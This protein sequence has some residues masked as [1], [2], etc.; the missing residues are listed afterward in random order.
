[1]IFKLIK[2]LFISIFYFFITTK[3]VFSEI[4]KDFNFIGNDRISD[5]TIKMFSEISIDEDLDASTLN[6]ILKNLYNTNF[7][8]NI[9]VKLENNI[10]EI[11]V[12]ENPIIEK[13]NYDGIK[14]KRINELIR[15]KTILKSRSSYNEF[16]LKKDIENIKS[17]L[18]ELGYY[19]PKINTYIE[20]K[21][22]NKI[23]VKYNLI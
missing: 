23:N 9:S 12:V 1:M 10:L 22:D 11:K 15:K 6:T 8:E 20:K 4:V 7:F 21:N 13:I 16:L 3:I 5:E 18:K 2:I 14:S 17:V 19:F